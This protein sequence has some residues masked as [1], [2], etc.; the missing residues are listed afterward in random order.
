M[1]IACPN[2]DA[3]FELDGNKL[4][5]NGKWVRCSKCTHEW[6][7]NPDE[8]TLAEARD[9]IQKVLSSE[10]D[11]LS[12][13]NSSKEPPPPASD[14]EPPSHK[15]NDKGRYKKQEMLENEPV[16][17]LES[18]LVD[19]FVYRAPLENRSSF[20]GTFLI[21]IS[22]IVALLLGLYFFRFSIVK[23]FP[24][25]QPLYESLEI[26]AGIPNLYFDLRDKSYKIIPDDSSP[27][28]VVSG[29]VVNRSS[30]V[31]YP[32]SLRVSLKG[33]GGCHPP[34]WWGKLIG[35]V[36]SP[37]EDGVCIVQRLNFYPVNENLFP[38]ESKRFM[39]EIPFAPEVALKDVYLD[40]A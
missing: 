36:K 8:T 17:D 29:E 39:A 7:Q 18:R 5:P 32:P 38:T 4:L 10:S 40:F 22:M 28:V 20:K 9:P 14:K 37:D 19:E 3:R 21:I 23:W 30:E 11:D 24:S 25:T 31:K 15:G 1:I 35:D 13:D 33:K 12:L 16:P 34:S 2:C 6:H 27:K 26:R